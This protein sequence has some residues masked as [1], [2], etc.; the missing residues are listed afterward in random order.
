MFFDRRISHL[1]PVSLV[2]GIL[3]F[4]SHQP[5]DCL[6]IPDFW[7]ADKLLHSLAYGALGISAMFSLDSEMRRNRKRICGVIVVAF[8]IV[9]GIS[10]EFHQ[11]FIPG[12]TAGFP[13][14]AADTVG[15]ILAVI[16]WFSVIERAGNH[17]AASQ[18]E[19]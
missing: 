5:G 4:L 3:F 6:K 7:Q 10:D 13:D 15:G 11:S 16:F 8:C 1:I 18:D 2:M 12:R 19:I 14:V 9:Y 17:L